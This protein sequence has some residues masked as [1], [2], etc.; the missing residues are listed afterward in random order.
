DTAAAMGYSIFGLTGRNDDQKTATVANLVKVGYDEFTADNFYTKWTG[1]GA[2][3]QPAYVTCATAK[4]TTVEY[5]AQ[6]RKH[7]EQ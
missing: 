3:Q 6:T 5:K 1:V 4:C 7:I 2:S